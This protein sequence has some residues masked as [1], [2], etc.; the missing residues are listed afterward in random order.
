MSSIFTKI[1]NFDLTGSIDVEAE[2]ARLMK[3]LEAIKKDQATAK[4][5]LENEKLS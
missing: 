4:V 2:R 5:K 1:V 3:D